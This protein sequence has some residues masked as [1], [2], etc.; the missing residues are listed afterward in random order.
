MQ[1]DTMANIRALH[2][3]SLACMISNFKCMLKTCVTAY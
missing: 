1:N 2:M 3:L